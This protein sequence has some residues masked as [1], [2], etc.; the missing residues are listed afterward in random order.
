MIYQTPYALREEFTRRIQAMLRQLELKYEEIA[1]V[2]TQLDQL[3]QQDV[4]LRQEFNSLQA[5]TWRNA[6]SANAGAVSTMSSIHLTELQNSMQE[7]DNLIAIRTQTYDRLIQESY[8]CVS[9]LLSTINDCIRC[10]S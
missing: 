7:L 5:S 10:E 2:R 4:D 6:I 9:R 1:H 8:K 3:R